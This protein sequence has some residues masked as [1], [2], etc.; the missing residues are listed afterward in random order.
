[1]AKLQIKHTSTPANP[2]LALD[3]GE[4]SIEMADPTRLWVGVPTSIN[5][6]AKKLLIDLSA[7]GGTGG[8]AL[9]LLNAPPAGAAVGDFWWD[10]GIG[11]LFVNYS[12]GDTVQW[13]SAIAVPEAG[14]PVAMTLNFPAAPALNQLYPAPAVAGVPLY[15]WD[16]EKWINA[17]S[18]QPVLSDGS[19]VMTGALK[20]PAGDPV[21]AN[22]AARKGYVDNAI[23]AA[24]GG[25]AATPATA[26]PLM[27]GVAAVGVGTK[28]AREDHI[29]PSDTSRVIKAGDRMTGALRVG[30]AQPQAPN[31]GVVSAS[32]V[33]ADANFGLNAYLNVDGSAWVTQNT[34]Y[35]MLIVGDPATGNLNFHVSPGSVPAGT[36]MALQTTATLTPGGQWQPKSISMI[37]DAGFGPFTIYRSNLTQYGT[38]GIDANGYQINVSGGG[39]PINF[40]FSGVLRA[41]F[42]PVGGMS[43][44]QPGSANAVA[45]AVTAATASY[46]GDFRASG[47]GFAALL[48]YAVG[49]SLYGMCG[50]NLSGTTY[51]YYGNTGA[52]LAAGAWQTSDARV[53]S[54]TKDLDTTEAL[55]AVNALTV[56]EFTPAN[57]AA[58]EMFF[59][60]ADVTNE[61]LY[62]WNAQ[63][64]E[65][66]LP[67]AVR[68]IGIPA[69]DRVLRAAL[70]HIDIPEL[71]SKEAE[72]LGAEEL[73]IKAINDR[74]MLT[75]LWSAVQRL[76]A[77]SDALRAELDALKAT[78][79]EP[80][81]PQR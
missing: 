4:L 42:N 24:V 7:S 10:T 74:Y 14:A 71:D 19:V 16:G 66:V 64:V 60:R 27:D 28:Y 47:P 59:G 55:A 57:P 45:L 31:S 21:A 12:D 72:A 36:Q 79:A 22:D 29:H 20:L 69:L 61:T 75:T 8:V 70:K 44:Y 68:D 46:A 52:F 62:G 34:G 50:E 33:S 73:S 58:R 13:V 78:T 77:Q 18:R 80:Q 25:A 1:M 40:S 76:S 23:S 65:Q 39:L 6:A 48:G 67:I 30:P 35:G 56:K 54:V 17:P 5:P 2:P 49:T 15:K 32:V 63:E 41:A 53:K 38:L 51:S 9:Y 26:A 11:N 43:I 81:P 3:P 37:S